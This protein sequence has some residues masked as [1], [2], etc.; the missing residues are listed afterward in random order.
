MPSLAVVEDLDVL[1]DRSLSLLPGCRALMMHEFILQCSLKAFHRRIVVAIAPARYRGAYGELLQPCFE[2]RI[3]SGRKRFAPTTATRARLITSVVMR[4]PTA[5][6]TTMVTSR[7]I[8]SRD[9]EQRMLS[10]CS[11][12]FVGFARESP[13]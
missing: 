10:R 5:W 13:R 9:N 12:F 7:V 4:A 1:R 11:A 8:P 3:S 2:C 6:P